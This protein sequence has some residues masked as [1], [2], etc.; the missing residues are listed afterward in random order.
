MDLDEKSKFKDQQR[1][2]VLAHR[3]DAQVCFSRDQTPGANADVRS[4]FDLVHWK[5][6]AN[7]IIP[8]HLLNQG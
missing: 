8:S 5:R 6:S 7:Y 1:D 3:V 2:I 4:T